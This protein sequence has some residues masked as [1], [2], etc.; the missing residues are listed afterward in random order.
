[1]S[2][3]IGDDEREARREYRRALN[4][5][6]KETQA[7]YDAFMQEIPAIVDRLVK[8]ARWQFIHTNEPVTTVEVQINF[9]YWRISMNNT[10]REALLQAMRAREPKTKSAS[11]IQQEP[12]EDG[13]PPCAHVTFEPAL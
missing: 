11:I 13:D 2:G 12:H 1:M 6:D 7:A 10:T 9:R 5:P 8:Q 3:I 4:A